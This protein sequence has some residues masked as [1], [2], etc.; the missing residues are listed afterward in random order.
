MS[1]GNN[2][3][4]SAVVRSGQVN[5]KANQ[6]VGPSVAR[7]ALI[8][9]PP[10]ND[11]VVTLS[12]EPD[13]VEGSGLIL[14]TGHIIELTFERHGSAVQGPWYAVSSAGSVTVGFLDV[15]GYS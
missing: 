4:R 3:K 1:N 13:L 7:V 8:F 15:S 2:T 12:T 6:L 10:S 5:T 11:V 14:K 9:T